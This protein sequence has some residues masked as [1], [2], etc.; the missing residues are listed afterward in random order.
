MRRPLV[1]VAAVAVMIVGVTVSAC[2]GD[3][4]AQ[5]ATQ[6]TAS[7]GVT[8]EA[9]SAPREVYCP[10]G[11]GYGG[12][13]VVNE[14]P[15]AVLITIDP[16]NPAYWVVSPDRLQGTRI[17]AEMGSRGRSEPIESCFQA[18]K[19]TAAN[20]RFVIGFTPAPDPNYPNP[21][22][23]YM[24]IEVALKPYGP[25]DGRNRFVGGNWLRWGSVE[26]GQCDPSYQRRFELAGHSP[27][28]IEVECAPSFYTYPV[29]V[30]LR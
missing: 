25:T 8:R 3:D 7:T 9:A 15:Y 10:D 21:K 30:T 14:R 24:P 19:A 13:R 11:W 12:I 5:V 20:A 27:R 18:A 4:A 23:F 29:V 17:Q 22:P 16:V 6:P 26:A 28:T 1:P 2:G